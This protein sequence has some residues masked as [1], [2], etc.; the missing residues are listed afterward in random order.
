MV[1]ARIP[2]DVYERGMKNLKNIDSSV[3]D[4]VR[5]AFEYVISSKELP[6][7]NSKLI[8]PGKKQLSGT[9]AIEFN[10]MFFCEPDSLELPADFDF[11]RE[12]S[13][14]LKSDYEALS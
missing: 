4:L 6:S 14:D 13:N 1:S 7:E 2:T 10:E 5:A 9:Q 12:L 11:K 3:T 8:E